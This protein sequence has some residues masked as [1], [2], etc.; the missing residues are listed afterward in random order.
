MNFFF[1]VTKIFIEPIK[2]WYDF[3]EPNNTVRHVLFIWLFVL[4]TEIF[5]WASYPMV[6]NYMRQNMQ[7]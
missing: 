4:E 7:L 2:Y 3:T 6:T 5:I 1:L